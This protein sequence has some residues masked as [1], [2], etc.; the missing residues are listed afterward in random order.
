MERHP[1]YIPFYWD[2]KE[3]KVWLE[4]S[5][6]DEELL[7]VNSLTTGIGSNDIGLDR[8]QLG[9]DCVVKFQR[10]GPKVLLTQVNYGFR[11]LSDNPYE[12]KSVE[13]AFAQSVHWG[14]KVE[15]EED[16]RVLVDATG[17]L[18]R[19]AKNVAAR[20]KEKEQGEYELDETR[21]AVYLPRSRNFPLNTELE[22]TLTFKGKNPG[23][24]VKSVAPDPSFIT[25]RQHHSFLELPDA[26][27]RPRRY[28]PRASYFGIRYMDFA[29][30]VDQ[31]VEKRFICRHR[32]EKKSP[33]DDVSEPVEP[34]VYYVDR[35]I[36][37]PI[38]GAVI[39]GASW[40]NQAFEA[41]GYRDAFRVEL[42]PEDADPM[43]A[44]YNVINWVHRSTRGWSYGNAVT[45]PRTGEII[46]G[47][48]SLC[49]LRIRQDFLIAQGLVADYDEEHPDSGKMMEMA[50]A[51]I[52]QLSVH[53]V[54]HTLGLGHNYCSHVNGRASVMDYPAPLVKVSEDR[55]DLSEAY[56]TGVG[57]WDKV[58][59]A[60]G[61][62]DFPEG[63]DED[64]AL[65]GALRKAF[66]GGLIFAPSQDAGP[67]SP[68]PHA[69][70]WVNGVDAVDE[71]RHVMKVRELALKGFTER[72][73]RRGEPMASLEEPLVPLYLFHR[74]QVEAA[75]SLIGGLYYNYNLRG[76]VQAGP[77]IVPGDQQRRALEA[78]LETIA[79][80][81]LALGEGLLSLIPPRPQGYPQTR[82]LFPGHTGYPFDPLGAA[83]AAANVTLSVLMHPERAAR[84]VEYHARD[85]EA[86]GLAEVLDEIIDITWKERHR[87][88]YHAE[89][90][91]T[92]DH[93]VLYHL[94]GLAVNMETTPAVRAT[95]SL[96]LSE[97]G[98]Y[99]RTMGERIQEPE[100]RAHYM[101][102][103]S[104]ITLFE[105]SPGQVKLT[106]PLEPPMG[107][108]I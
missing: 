104:Q 41:C 61:Y 93:V 76:D 105:E 72:R 97:L 47:H 49:S 12:V 67:G 106:K 60:Y 39:E 46:K 59:V 84:L 83:E 102:G 2:E 63:V 89:V 9:S 71:L 29:A 54:G 53:E 50:L 21:S 100:Q 40:W 4:L 56:E 26:D 52:R 28:D 90:Q 95:A 58:S 1:G 36:P 25:V 64:A 82:D 23:D 24:W 32:L 8:N 55:L 86:P 13:E 74:Y 35:G 16:G 75:A 88:A 73:I 37:E 57:E 96:K 99:L 10:V 69:A 68:H 43:D 81:Q 98:D 14:F 65:D 17:F 91:R 7:Y 79:P 18:L 92:V 62:Q 31:N 34:I 27:Y 80:A 44:R 51:R 6:F 94:V 108:P 107:P 20:L 101:Y 42:L 85:P 30:P 15:A 77:R 45:D 87:D 11:A 3:G 5:R 33:E 19:D 78:L 48:V 22:A 70:S 66:D 103:A 38:R